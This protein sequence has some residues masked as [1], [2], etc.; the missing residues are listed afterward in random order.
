MKKLI[1]ITMAII[2]ILPYRVTKILKLRIIL[3]E[4]H[5]EQT[6]QKEQHL[7]N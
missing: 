1:F 7:S 6:I 4:L 5:G 3:L 2:A